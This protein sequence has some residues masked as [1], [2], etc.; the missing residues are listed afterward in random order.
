VAALSKV[1]IQEKLTKMPGWSHAGKSLQKKFIFRS[2]VEAMA[3]VNKIAE[4]AENAGHHPDITIS[5]NRVGI[6]LSTHSESGVT[7][8]D[9]DLAN[10]IDRIRATMP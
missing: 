2:F 7:E 3:F 10:Q 6:N 9:F 1:E 4:A 5:Y 8:R